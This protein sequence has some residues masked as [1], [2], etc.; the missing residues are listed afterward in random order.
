MRGY[1]ILF[2]VLGLLLLGCISY[3]SEESGTG[4]EVI[5]ATDQ[6]CPGCAPSEGVPEEVPQVEEGVGAVPEEELVQGLSMEEA[7]EIA[8]NSSCT[9]E[10]NITN[11]YT[12][13]NITRT[14]WFDMD[15]ER[16][17]CAPAC[18]VDELNKSAEINW[19]CTG[20]IIPENETAGEFDPYENATGCVGPNETGYDIYTQDEVWFNGSIHRDK[21]ALAAIVK[22]YYCKDGEVKSVNTE[23]P[24]NY[25]CRDGRCKPMEYA[26]RKSYGNDTT[27]KGRIMVSKGLNLILDEYDECLDDGT[28]KEW[29]CAENGSGYYLEL[30]CGSGMKCREDEG[31]CVRSICEETDNGIDPEH[32]GKVSFRTREDEYSDSCVSDT[33]LK[34]YYCYGD[35]YRS[36]TFNCIG[37]CIDDEC[38]PVYE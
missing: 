36:Q 29:M 12:Y 14:W 31:R 13:N 24:S 15:I 4:E 35:G 23:C 7:Q 9:V 6:E 1:I 37:N 21:C 27:I 10:G 20:L 38:V 26:C 18:V 11:N 16:A 5:I 2:G 22:D 17:G 30:Y 34:E 33:R 32:A 25:D 3:V 28:I 8:L 19:R